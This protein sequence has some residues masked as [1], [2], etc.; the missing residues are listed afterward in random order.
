MASGSGRLSGPACPAALTAGAQHL[1]GTGCQDHV[2]SV[3]GSVS[4]QQGT[5][6]L[7]VRLVRCVLSRGRK[8]RREKA[9]FSE[10]VE[11][12]LW[13]RVPWPPPLPGAEKHCT[14]PTPAGPGHSVPVAVSS[15]RSRT[16]AHDRTV[17]SMTPGCTAALGSARTASAGCPGC[18]AGPAAWSQTQELE[19]GADAGA[20]SRSRNRNREPDRNRELGAGAGS[21]SP[22]WN[23]EPELEPRARARARAGT[24]A[25]AVGA[26]C[27][28]WDL[29][30]W[31]QRN[32]RQRVF[33]LGHSALDGSCCP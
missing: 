10:R 25:R 11:G 31:P 29:A 17:G 6:P 24:G 32:D 30:Q 22:S 14:S 1:R 15:A 3:V 21:R 18:W 20:R 28:T 7:P 2:G 4:A 33:K 9:R 8:L 16:L 13:S 12:S 23:Q 26:P 5:G 19:P 27:L